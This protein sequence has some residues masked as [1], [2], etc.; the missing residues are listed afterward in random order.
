MNVVWSATSPETGRFSSAVMRSDLKELEDRFTALRS[1]GE[2]YVEV[3][4]PTD[5]S[6]QVSVSFR[7]D[8]AVVQQLS[9]PETPTSSLLVGD[10]SVPA[11]AV[12]DV[13]VMDDPAVFT[14][15]FVMSVDRAWDAVRD[16]VRTGSPADL[17][18]WY[19]L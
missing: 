3:E 9:D 10:G 19:Q 5:D 13:P 14:G 16:F 2:G 17:G 18:E 4:L 15:D 1:I 7:G 8:R 12:V 11:E 6:P